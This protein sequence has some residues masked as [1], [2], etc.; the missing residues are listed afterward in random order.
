MLHSTYCTYA[1]YKPLLAVH[2]TQIHAK[3]QIRQLLPSEDAA[4]TLML[5]TFFIYHY[6]TKNCFSQFWMS[7]IALLFSMHLEQLN[8]PSIFQSSCCPTPARIFCRLRSKLRSVCC[9]LN[10]S[11]INCVAYIGWARNWKGRLQMLFL[12]VVVFITQPPFV[13][14]QGSNVSFV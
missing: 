6:V 1:M 9:K 3:I 5:S 7:T 8:L 12:L 4:T 11:L 10:C 13:K 2:T 14:A